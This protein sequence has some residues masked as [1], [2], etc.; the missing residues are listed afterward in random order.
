MGLKKHSACIPIY[1][2]N[3]ILYVTL[4]YTTT[5]VERNFSEHQGNLFNFCGSVHVTYRPQLK[6]MEF[7]LQMIWHVVPVTDFYHR[8]NNRTH[9]SSEITQSAW[10]LGHCVQWSIFL[11]NWSHLPV[12]YLKVTYCNGGGCGSGSRTGFLLIGW[13]VVRSLVIPV[14]VLHY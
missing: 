1:A 8:S 14:C 3:G 2:I 9:H 11:R 10:T 13:V 7:L 5:Q 4:H 6:Y 12:N